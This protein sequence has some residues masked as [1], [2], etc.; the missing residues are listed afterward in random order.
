MLLPPILAAA[1]ALAFSCVAYLVTPAPLMTQQPLPHRNPV[2]HEPQPS[3]PAVSAIPTPSASLA[4]ANSAP[5]LAAEPTDSP[6]DFLKQE[7]RL[8]SFERAVKGYPVI[9]RMVERAMEDDRLQETEYQAIDARW[10][11]IKRNES[12]RIRRR[13]PRQH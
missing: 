7:E 1:T 4:T 12:K 6:P 11:R 3:F 9:R 5:A 2:A 13:S 10:S 8:A